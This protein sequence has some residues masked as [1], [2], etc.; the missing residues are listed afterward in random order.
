MSQNPESPLEQD[1]SKPPAPKPAAPRRPRRGCTFF[2]GLFLL[3]AVALFVVVN[4][5]G[6][7]LLGGEALPIGDAIG[8]VRVENLIYS[9]DSVAQELKKYADS[10]RVRGILLRIDSPGGVVG[11]AQEMY[12]AI[13]QA[14]QSKPVY[15]SLGNL[16]ASGGYYVAAACDRIFANPGTMTGSIG[17]IFELTNWQDLVNKIG[18]K[19]DAVK[20]GQYTDIGSP[21]RPMTEEERRLMQ[22]MIDDVYQQFVEAILATRA[23]ALTA[24]MKNAQQPDFPVKDKPIPPDATVRQYLEALCDGRIYSGRQALRLGLVDEL[25]AREAAIAKLAEKVGLPT[26]PKIVEAPSKISVLQLLLGEAN[27]RLPLPGTTW[28]MPMYLMDAGR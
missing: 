24:A 3:L 12:D 16:A 22:G 9:A 25:G 26:P 6:R 2:V 5:M 23:E 11:A 28:P 4:V 15:A 8:L 21:N 19:F 14:R 20:S 18:V 7:F 1:Q 13:V 17:V 27:S 10:G